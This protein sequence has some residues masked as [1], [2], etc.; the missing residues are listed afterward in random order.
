VGRGA[1]GLAAVLV[2]AADDLA[3]VEVA[4]FG[5]EEAFAGAL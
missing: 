1:L 2:G 4:V 5:G 3:A